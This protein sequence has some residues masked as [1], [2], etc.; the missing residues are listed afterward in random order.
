[1]GPLTSRGSQKKPQRQETPKLNHKRGGEGPSQTIH[2]TYR[3]GVAALGEN[4]SQV[5]CENSMLHSLCPTTTGP[6]SSSLRTTTRSPNSAPMG[7]PH[8]GAS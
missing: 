7:R 5:L 1:M 6:F 2:S 3:E 4:P 8:I